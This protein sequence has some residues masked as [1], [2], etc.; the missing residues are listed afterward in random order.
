MWQLQQLAIS[1]LNTAGEVTVTYQPV[2]FGHGKDSQFLS[3]S[4]RECQHTANQNTPNSVIMDNIWDDVDVSAMSHIHLVNH[5]NIDTADEDTDAAAEAALR[6]PTRKR[7][8][9]HSEKRRQEIL[10]DI[11][12]LRCLVEAADVEADGTVVDIV[13]SCVKKCISTINASSVINMPTFVTDKPAAPT[14]PSNK[15]TDK[16]RRLHSSKKVCRRK[17]PGKRLAKPTVAESGMQQQSFM[18]QY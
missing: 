10:S 6:L 7:R 9:K 2:H 16:R 15:L 17:D 12:H 18:V 1:V 8:R 13:R 5:D 3:P 14:E 4:S 11:D